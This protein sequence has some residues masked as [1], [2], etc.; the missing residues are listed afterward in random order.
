MGKNKFLICGIFVLLVTLFLIFPVSAFLN[1]TT[2]TANA[3]NVW[4]KGGSNQ[5]INFTFLFTTPYNSSVS[6]NSINFT[7][8]NFTIKAINKTNSTGW[9]CIGATNYLNCST[10]IPLDSTIITLNVTLNDS[11]YEIN[12]TITINISTN[13]SEYGLGNSNKNQL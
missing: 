9:S 7:S 4:F 8:T 11:A 5:A 3:T 1:A 12:H 6:V 13:A 2:I 10:V